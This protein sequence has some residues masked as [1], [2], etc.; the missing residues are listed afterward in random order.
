MTPRIRLATLSDAEAIAAIYRPVVE[1]TTISF[2]TVAPDRVEMAKRLADTL[3]VASLARVRGGR[4]RG[5]LRLR[6]ETPGT[7]RVSVVSG[8][9]RI[10]GRGVPPI[11]RGRGL[12]QSLFAILAAQGF[13][14]AFAGIALPN[15][16]SVALHEAVGFEPL[17]VYRRVG[18]KLGAWHDVGWWQLALRAH[19]ASPDA[20]LPARGRGAARR[21]G[22]AAGVWRAVHSRHRRVTTDRGAPHRAA[23]GHHAEHAEHDRRRP[24]LTI[25]LILQS[26]H[27]PQALLGW[28]AGASWRWPTVSCGPSSAPRCQA[29]AAA[30]AIC[31]RRTARGPGPPH[32]LPVPVADRHRVPA[33]DGVG[34]VGFAHYLQYLVPSLG[35]WQMKAV[36][37]FVCL[38]SAAL[39][40]RRIDR[41]GRWGTVFGALVFAAIGW[42]IL[43]GVL[44]G[45][46]AALRCRRA[47]A[48]VSARSGRARQRDALLGLRL[49][50]LQQ[51]LQLRG[52]G[53]A[54]RRDDSAL[55]RALVPAR[56]RALPGDEPQH[57]E[58]DAVAGRRGVAKRGS[59]SSSR[60]CGRGL[61][62][63]IMT[64]AD[65]DHHLRRALR[66]DV[67]HLAHPYAAAADGHFFPAFARLHP[68]G[69]FPSFSVVFVGVASAV[70][71]LLELDALIAA[72]VAIYV[73]IGALP[74]IGAVTALRRR[75]DIVRP[76]SMWGY[77]LP[78]LV[79]AAGWIAILV[80][81]GIWYMRR[82]RQPAGGGHRVLCVAGPACRRM[83]LNANASG[84]QTC[85]MTRDVRE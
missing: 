83:A 23:R 30:T 7:R 84:L 2:E 69:H 48:A 82:R 11:G 68:S 40:Y 31:S 41:V 75:R 57:P 34:R 67:R 29:P 53:A 13:F 22:V 52:R 73:V 39:V 32:E 14:N 50:R 56:R 1:T 47:L 27:G 19:D 45:R 85:A 9:L 55:D 60:A 36:A 43:E 5:G 37:A 15:A 16:A 59:A 12:Y 49:S 44:H 81:S 38:L 78:S 4:P 70:A 65:P 35:P 26:M 33:D 79:A 66:G 64:W 63:T 71:C 25:P 17:G 54:T 51:H 72:L 46:A 24:F 62:A 6:H 3:D 58:R 42:V 10:R 8:H 80:T 77:P 76:F 21:L 20:P 28:I 61:A 74:I 18:F